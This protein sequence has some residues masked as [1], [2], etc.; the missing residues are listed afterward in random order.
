VT[1]G[2]YTF[3]MWEVWH[4]P[5]QEF[6]REQEGTYQ[7]RCAPTEFPG[8]QPTLP[9]KLLAMIYRPTVILSILLKLKPVGKKVD[10]KMN[11]KAKRERDRSRQ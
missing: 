1:T 6:G 11:R 7:L 5:G 4:I 2:D 10:T 3:L 8:P 9:T